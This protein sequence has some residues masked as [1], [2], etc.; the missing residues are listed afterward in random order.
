MRRNLFEAA[1]DRAPGCQ[2]LLVLTSQWPLPCVTFCPGK[3]MF[4]VR[5][6]GDDKKTGARGRRRAATLY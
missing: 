5:N 1:V 3:R 4:T 6:P 2:G